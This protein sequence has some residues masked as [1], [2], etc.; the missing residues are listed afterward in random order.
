MYDFFP[1]EQRKT[2]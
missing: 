1:C 2:I